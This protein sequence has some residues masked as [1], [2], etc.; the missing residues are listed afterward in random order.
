MP[1]GVMESTE[2]KEE[3]RGYELLK[4]AGTLVP[5]SVIDGLCKSSITIKGVPQGVVDS[6]QK[7]ACTTIKQKP[8][9]VFDTVDS[10]QLSHHQESL[11][12]H[13]PN[14]YERNCSA[15]VDP[16]TQFCEKLPAGASLIASFTGT[17]ALGA[18]TA[19]VEGGCNIIVKGQ[20]SIEVAAMVLAGKTSEEAGVCR[21]VGDALG[22]KSEK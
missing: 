18:V 11:P 9:S 8:V 7:A 14:K 13:L 10:L 3:A 17:P 20:A 2:P 22:K 1:I 21:L 5:D 4:R 12:T 15:V 6:V 16:I 19:V